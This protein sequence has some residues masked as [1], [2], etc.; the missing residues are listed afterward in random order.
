MLQQGPP[1]LQILTGPRQVGKTTCATAIAKAWPGPTRFASADTPRPPEPEWIQN[2]WQL[3]RAEDSAARP[4][5]LVLD[6][7]QKVKRWSEVV[8]ALWAA[9]S[10]K[11]RAAQQFC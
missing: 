11:T 3:A 10:A 1:L 4:A 9:S 5:L 7:V 6:E 2:E 8:K